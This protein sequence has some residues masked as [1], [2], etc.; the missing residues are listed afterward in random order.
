MTFDEPFWPRRSLFTTMTIS[1]L[2]RGRPSGPAAMPG[3][4]LMMFV[5]S[6]VMPLEISLSAP[7]RSTSALSG[8]PVVTSD[9]LKPAASARA[10]M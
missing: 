4:D 6:S 8:D 5:W 3:V 7:F 1:A 10:P 2:A 9:A